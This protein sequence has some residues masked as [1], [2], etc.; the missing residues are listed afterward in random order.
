MIA[1]TAPRNQF[2]DETLPSGSSFLKYLR[3]IILGVM[4]A[5]AFGHLGIDLG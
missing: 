2:R 5:I 4:D 1:G 3:T